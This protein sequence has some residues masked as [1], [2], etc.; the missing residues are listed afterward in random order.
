MSDM[1]WIVPSRSRPSNIA[2][3]I[4]TMHTTRCV[5]DLLVVI[6]NDD[7][8]LENYREVLLNNDR[9]PWLSYVESDRLRLVGS[10]NKFATLMAPNY[11]FIGFMGDDH[12]P[13]TPIWDGLMAAQLRKMGTGLVYGND[14][15]QGENLPTAVA[16][17]TDIISALGYMAPPTL[18]HLYV[19]NF[20]LELG[21]QIDRIE[22]MEHVVIEHMHPHA[23]KAEGDAQYDELN[24]NAQ[25]NRD[26]NAFETYKR[27][28]LAADV[29]KIKAVMR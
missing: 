6:D 19:D 25:H 28:G 7:P 21:R 1:L 27:K 17:T 2:D 11:D 23:G 5:A 20:W 9:L 10:L 29:E 4:A 12:R 22:Y 8:E 3:L 18:Q 24:S 26:K 16:M 13:K 14:L 15:F